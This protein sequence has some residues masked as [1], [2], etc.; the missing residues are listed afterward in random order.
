MIQTSTSLVTLNFFVTWFIAISSSIYV[1]SQRYELLVICF[2][3][4][5]CLSSRYF[6]L[7]F[8]KLFA[9]IHGSTHKSDLM[10]IYVERSF[11]YGLVLWFSMSSVSS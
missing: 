6:T 5:T 1:F 2:S 4:R 8:A 9:T 3:A 7:L 11:Y 10:E